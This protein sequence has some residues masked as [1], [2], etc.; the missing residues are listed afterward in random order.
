MRWFKF[1]D[2]TVGTKRF[3][4]NSEETMCANNQLTNC[5][6]IFNNYSIAHFH[7]LL[8][9]SQRFRAFVIFL[10]SEEEPKYSRYCGC[11]PNKVK[12]EMKSYRL[13]SIFN[14]PI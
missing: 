13:L 6:S 8:G 9:I 11:L 7:T 10:L 5:N 3:H 2:R 4:R 1:F 14:I 12:S